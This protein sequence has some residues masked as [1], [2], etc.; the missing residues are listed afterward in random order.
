MS[1]SNKQKNVGLYVYTNAGLILT[2]ALAACKSVMAKENSSVVAVL[3]ATRYCRFA[4]LGG[5]GQLL[6]KDDVP[7]DLNSTYEAR[8]FNDK[9]ELRWLHTSAGRGNA[10]LLTEDQQ[11]LQNFKGEPNNWKEESLSAVDTIPQSYLLWGE[12][13]PD[14]THAGWIKMATPRIGSYFAPVNRNQIANNVRVRL[15][16]REY[17]CQQPTHGNVYVGEERWMSLSV[18]DRDTQGGTGVHN[19]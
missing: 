9:A 14:Q 10:A 4:L 8:V 12:S 3:Y 7:I 11:S 5:E 1:E 17:L 18:A 19:G 16:A 13:V 6:G 2:E 15:N